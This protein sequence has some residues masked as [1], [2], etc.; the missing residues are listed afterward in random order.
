MA[1]SRKRPGLERDKNPH[2]IQQNSYPQ[3][4]GSFPWSTVFS[5]DLMPNGRHF[6]SLFQD[7]CIDD[8]ARDKDRAAKE[9]AS[10]PIEPKCQFGLSSLGYPGRT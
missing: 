4:H 6:N 8:S 10:W 2:P 5:R 7:W 3:S 1:R 9:V